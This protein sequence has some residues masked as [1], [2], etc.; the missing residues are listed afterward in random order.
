MANSKTILITG[1]GS[2]FGEGVAIGLAQLGH[3]VIAGVQIS[4]Q[5]TP[6][7][8]KAAKL[9]L[10]ANLRVEKLDILDSYDVAYALTW[11]IDVLFS[12]AGIGEAGP[13]FEIPMDLVRRNFETNVFA[14]LNLAQQFIKKFID[15]KKKGKVVF[16]SS[17]GGLFTPAGFGIYVS[18]KH[19]LESVAEALQQEVKPF[20]IQIQTVN[21]GPYLTG[22]NETMAETPFR[23]LDDNKNYTKKAD[24]KATFDAMLGVPEGRL[25]PNEMIEAM[26]R[27]VPAETGKFRNVVPQAIE[28]MLKESQKKGW[29]NTI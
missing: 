2:G 4:P 19:A 13:V 3:K 23:W 20:G 11:D 21:P 17:M 9:G 27:I 15:G 12:N 25:D 22:Y 14:P 26:I 5:V 6:L 16:T 24:L 18:T 29:E 7:R 1:A 8:E 10:E 28:D